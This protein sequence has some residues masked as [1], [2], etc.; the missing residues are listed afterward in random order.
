[1]L[2]VVVKLVYFIA[3]SRFSSHTVSMTSTSECEKKYQTLAL[4]FHGYTSL[5]AYSILMSTVKYTFLE[6]HIFV[7][8][9]MF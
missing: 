2:V 8:W 9:V 5:V 3:L 6:M 7:L 1:M 4:L